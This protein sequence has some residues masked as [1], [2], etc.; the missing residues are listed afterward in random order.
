MDGIRPATGN[1]VQGTPRQPAL[2]QVPVQRRHAERVRPGRASA[3][4]F[5]QPDAAAQFGQ[6]MGLVHVRI[7]FP[8]AGRVKADQT[9]KKDWGE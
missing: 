9:N 4:A 6:G 1:I 7:L 5:Q 3:R 8:S 2:G